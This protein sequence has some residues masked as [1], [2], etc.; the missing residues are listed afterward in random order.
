MKRFSKIVLLIFSFISSLN[1]ISQTFNYDQ[2]WKDIQKNEENGTFKS[3]L[4]LVEDI[5]SQA[6]KDNKT[7]HVIKALIK[8]SYIFFQTIEEKEEPEVKIIQNFEKEIKASKG[9]NQAILKYTLAKMYQQYIDQKSYQIEERTQLSE[10]PTDYRE[11]TKKDFYQQIKK[12]YDEA[13]KQAD[14]L[15]KNNLADWKLIIS[16]EKINPLRSTWLDLIV[17]DYSNYLNNDQDLQDDEKNLN[18]KL[19][20]TWQENLY[21]KHQSLG[22]ISSYL[23]W[24]SQSIE[25]KK[26]NAKLFDDLIAEYPDEP[27]NAQLMWQK[28]MLYTNQLDDDLRENHVSSNGNKDLMTAHKICQL[29]IEKHKNSEWNLNNRELIKSIEWHWATFEMEQSPLINK[30]IAMKISH[31]NLSK[32]FIKIYE[33]PITID[34]FFTEKVKNQNNKKI[35]IVGSAIKTYEVNLKAFDDFETHSTIFK[36][37]ALPQGQYVFVISNRDSLEGDEDKYFVNYTSIQ[38]SDV[39]AL[40]KDDFKDH[41]KI[42]LLNKR[43]GA[44]IENNSDWELYTRDF[45]KNNILLT[46][47]NQIKT[48]DK[49][50]ATLHISE[51]LKDNVRYNFQAVL[52]NKKT[53]EI[54]DLGQIYKSYY[55]E[56]LEKTTHIA[57]IFTDRAIYRPGQKLYFKAIVYQKEKEV[58]TIVKDK[59]IQVEI[60]NTNGQN[61]SQLKLTTNDF[62]SVFG[63]FI[64]PNDGL[65][66]DYYIYIKFED[67]DQNI[68]EHNFKVEEYKR[69]KFEITFKPLTDD[70]KLDV[71]ANVIGHGEAFSGAKISDAQVSYRVIRE[72]RFFHAL[73]WLKGVNRW[74]GWPRQSSPKE[75]A[76][77]TTTTDA[78]G[79]FII[80]FNTK[81]ANPRIDLPRTF[82]YKVIVNITDINGET[83][84]GEISLNAGDVPLRLNIESE[85]KVSTADFK[86]IKIKSFNLNDQKKETTGAIKIYQLIEPNRVIRPQSFTTD[87][88]YQMLSKDEFLKNF[89][90]DAFDKNEMNPQ[91]WERQLV[92]ELP[93]NTKDAETFS[94]DIKD[95]KHGHYAIEA[96]SII[97]K[98]TISTSKFIELFDAK[99]LK[100]TT[101]EFLSAHLDKTEYKVG[102]KAKIT[103]NSGIKDAIVFLS[104]ANPDTWLAE[105]IMLKLN[106]GTANYSFDVTAAQK[107]GM[108]ISYYIL[109]Q[110]AYHQNQLMAKVAPQKD[111]NLTITTKTFRDKLQPGVPEKWELTISGKDKDK[112]AAEVLATMY[113]ASLDQFVKHN[114][115]FNPR[116]YLPYFSLAEFNARQLALRTSYLNQAS[117]YSSQ[118]YPRYKNEVWNQLNFFGYY[119]GSNYHYGG[120]KF[121]TMAATSVRSDEVMVMEDKMLLNEELVEKTYYAGSVSPK[122][123]QGQVAGVA[124]NTNIEKLE[125]LD[126]SSIKVRTNL[127]E[128]AFFFPNLMTDAEGNIKLEFTTPEA[129][130]KWKLMLVAHTQELHHGVYSTYVQTQKELMVVPNAPR[131]LRETDQI[132]FSSKISN[133]SDKVLN[134]KAKLEL[135]DAFTLKPIDLAFDN[136]QSTKTFEV[137]AG[138]NTVVNWDLKIPNTHQAIVYRVVA[139]AAEFSDGEENTLPVLPNRML[140]TETMPIS[141]REGQTKTFT[142]DKLKNQ[143]ST[144]LQN[145]NLSLE[146]TT[147]PLWT[148]I[149]ALPYLREFPHECNEQL[150]SRI[151]GNA[152]STHILNSSPKIKKVFDDWNNK[153]LQVSN[154]EK[155][156][157]LKQLL[158]EETPWLREAQSET[159]QMKRLAVFFEINQMA[160]ELKQAKD[161]LLQRQMSNGAFSWYGGDKADVYITNHIIG[162]TGKLRKML[163]DN[164]QNTLGQDMEQMALKAIDFSDN[165]M[166]EEWKKTPKKQRS[167][168]H[169]TL[170]HYLYARSLWL[171]DK[172]LPSSY[173]SIKQE[174]FNE[175]LENFT[176][177]DI[178][179]QGLLSLTLHRYDRKKDAGKVLFAVEEKSTMSDEMG[180]YWQVNQSG[181]AWH[182]APIE[183][184][185]IIIEAYDEIKND[186]ESVE[187][188]KVWLVK[189]KQTNHWNSTKATTEAIYALMSIG[190]SWIDAEEGITVK[191]GDHQIYPPSNALA[192]GVINANG[193]YKQSWKT[194]EIKP[195]MGSISVDKKSPG[196][197]YGGMYWQY[198]ENLNKITPAQT[199]LKLKKELYLKTNTT[200]GPKLEMISENAP[201]KIGDIVT[202]RC[203]IQ[204]DRALSYIH[205]KDMRASGFEPVNVLSSYKYKDGLGYYE[206]T[207]DAATNFF[208]SYMAPGVYVFEYDVKANNA[209]TFSNGISSIQ[210]MYAPEFAAHTQGQVVKIV[211]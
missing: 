185:T 152:L 156:Q 149:G 59:A 103:F 80:P 74:W 76:Q 50:I 2:K 137:N 12:L 47:N 63:E 140:V 40:R 96:S 145:F 161:K 4:K 195:D 70:Y 7:D 95:L 85:N 34:N 14:A 183:T 141:V 122:T 127:Q 41:L 18:K 116:Q 138:G 61:V 102:D 42:Q 69:P 178:S 25:A 108:K 11:W 73:P 168:L 44:P 179:F 153:G 136:L 5:L 147:N 19:I 82:N 81:T 128:T 180:K 87:V 10:T 58:S 135:L 104:I 132:T 22:K 21:K 17:Y 204:T 110:N 198:F 150:F 207:R 123:L 106:N 26:E 79:Q 9:E 27:Y 171:K 20:K 154:L 146:L 189:N 60:H 48:D 184:Q 191:M 164:F 107:Y 206:S 109:N 142:F 72:E 169:H 65:T 77:G 176:K 78:D 131:F 111:Y 92:L 203:I 46:F 196:V 126:T 100:V 186:I 205:L 33:T 114:F 57:D 201:I 155:N 130:T 208:I 133:L 67:N 88:D 121:M 99:T 210:N 39:V 36:I 71:D 115:T 53:K 134:G 192:F 162:S 98:D 175:L 187:A 181:W 159:E 101:H 129:L 211:E 144:T 174:V 209:G 157:E 38:V 190:K 125:T 90:F 1:M 170:L 91:Q 43:N 32:V 188:M 167:W 24:K 163:D 37:D 113:D 31:R 16:P 56:N 45:N 151:Y 120:K 62:G 105:N 28:A 143:S 172:P 55:S 117:S 23:Y 13:L 173:N 194:T 66:G 3:N 197:M 202:V 35:S 52:I 83:Q 148:V 89:P 68:G 86:S 30:P 64:L 49:G 200:S 193:Y 124:I 199:N 166:I 29:A 15:Y 51:K 118:Y 160:Q 8:Q 158:L 94:F 93:F 97:E 139:Q 54:I 75:I 182:Q 165:Y 112:L 84:T 177:Q 119:F 6:K